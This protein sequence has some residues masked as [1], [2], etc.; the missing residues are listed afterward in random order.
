VPE[1]EAG[2]PTTSLMPATPEMVIALE[3]NSV[4]PRAMLA[5]WLECEFTQ[6]LN[7]LKMLGL[8]AAPVGLLPK[9][10]GKESLIPTKNC[11]DASATGPAVAPFAYSKPAW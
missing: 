8:K 10:A 2:R 1:N 11:C 4:S 5:H 6:A 7:K 9:L 3:L